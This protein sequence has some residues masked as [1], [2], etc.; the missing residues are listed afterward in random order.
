[1]LDVSSVDV[2]DRA[3]VVGQVDTPK[4][5]ARQRLVGVGVHQAV[6]SAGECVRLSDGCGSIGALRPSRSATYRGTTIGADSALRRFD[7]R[8]QAMKSSGLLS[9]EATT[10]L[11]RPA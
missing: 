4:R 8:R 6:V 3:P 5:K 7:S 2:V 11:P 9:T 1:V 10:P